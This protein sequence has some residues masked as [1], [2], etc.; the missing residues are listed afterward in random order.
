MATRSLLRTPVSCGKLFYAET[1]AY[2]TRLPVTIN[3]VI[4]LLTPSDPPEHRTLAEVVWALSGIIGGP[5]T[6]DQD[7]YNKRR[8]ELVDILPA[9]Q[10][11]LSIRRMLDSYDSAIIPIVSDPSLRE[12]YLT[13]HGGVRIGRLLEDMDI[14][15]VHLGWCNYV[16]R[17]PF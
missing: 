8:Q 16:L 3:Q 14:F 17:V 13:N 7:L 12:R 4:P 5:S 2:T 9:K 10:D 11:D 1:P 15:A 6:Y